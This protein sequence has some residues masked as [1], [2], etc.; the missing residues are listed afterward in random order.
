MFFMR[1]YMK[2]SFEPGLKPALKLVLSLVKKADPEC[3]ALFE[4]MEIPTFTSA[5]VLTW[6]SHTLRSFAEITRVFDVCLF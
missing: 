2:E 4:D 6:Y 5:W 1:D 3:G